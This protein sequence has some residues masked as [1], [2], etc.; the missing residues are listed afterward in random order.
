MA[1]AAFDSF[2][3]A[4]ERWRMN[5]QQR[6]HYREWAEP[7]SNRV[8]DR[9]GCVE[10]AIYHL[11][12]GDLRNR[13]YAA[14]FE[15]LKEFHFDP[16]SDIAVAESGCLRWNTEKPDLHEYVRNHFVTRKEDG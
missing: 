1:C 3:L 5:N 6:T 9:V 15:G 13:R 14:R 11:W 2:E 16:Y 8:R 7:F 10:G 4:V 12:H